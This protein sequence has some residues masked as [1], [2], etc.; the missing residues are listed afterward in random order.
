MS[1]IVEDEKI[2]RERLE[3]KIIELEKLNQDMKKEMEKL[4]KEK[5][6]IE[7][8]NVHYKVQAKNYDLIFNKQKTYKNKVNFAFTF[9]SFLGKNACIYGSFV[10]KLFDYSLRLDKI[11]NKNTGS[12]DNSDINFYFYLYDY[13]DKNK[14][15]YQ[16]YELI[17]HIEVSTLLS[18]YNNSINPFE[19]NGYVYINSSFKFNVYDNYDKIIPRVILQFKHKDHLQST[20]PE[21]YINVDILAWKKNENVDFS[22]NSFIINNNGLVYNNDS[23]YE[24]IQYIQDIT[25]NETCYI[26]D[27]KR[28]QDLAFPSQ[29][30]SVPREV[31]VK[32]LKKLY[33][34]ISMTCLRIIN[35][36]YSIYG[37]VPEI[38]IESN[39]DCYLTSC[40]APYPKV[41]LECDHWISLMGYRGIL[42]K[43]ENEFTQS[44]KCPLCRNDLKIKFTNKKN[45]DNSIN[46]Q[47]ILN[48]LKT[49]ET[50]KRSMD[51]KLI[52]NEAIE[53]I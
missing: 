22:V 7:L 53:Y 17:R 9:L 29:S 30:E 13:G 5:S 10:R 39:E 28:Y 36:Q 49:F 25:N 2:I 44:I 32:H 42:D 15:S 47:P 24:F 51:L 37:L 50:I 33:N 45:T 27:L 8:E 23:K 11:Q 1:N 26:K 12:L 43:G 38:E 18:K 35:N 21:H 46:I 31:K 6:Y 41:L 40:K 52:S 14:V 19:I 48:Y 4:Q 20:K 34:M 3:N 16:F